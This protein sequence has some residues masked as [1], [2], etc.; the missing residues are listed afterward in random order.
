[1][2][3]I[4]NT[5]TGMINTLSKTILF[6][7][8]AFLADNCW[9]EW[10]IYFEKRGYK[11]IC[12]PWPH[13]DAPAESLRNNDVENT[14]ASVRLNELV[15]YFTGIV[16]SLPDKPILVGHSV[17][18]LIVQLLLQRKLG[19]A[20]IALHSFPPRRAG[21]RSLSLIKEWWEPMGFFSPAAENY[22]I[23]FRKWKRAVA[24]GM[25]GD[26]QKDLYYRYAVPESKRLI[27]DLF[28]GRERI[29]FSSP[30]APLLLISGGE[31]RMI[32]PS[33]CYKNSKSYSTDRSTTNYIVFPEHNHLIFNDPERREIAHY[34]LFWLQGI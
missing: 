30:H 18:G 4:K 20:G 25:D 13:K 1:L 5:N 28:V 16:N 29:N 8:G 11:T 9:D 2:A 23:S 7:P 19:T 15:N 32:P 14:I 24:N 6:I 26:L 17:G 27:R 12:V 33:V 10:R 34:I 22:L 31:D 21:R 3:A